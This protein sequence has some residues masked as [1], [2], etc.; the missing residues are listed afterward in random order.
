MM[1]SCGA[2]QRPWNLSLAYVVLQE[3]LS[4]GRP[5]PLGWDIHKGS[6]KTSCVDDDP[7][8]EPHILFC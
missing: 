6:S 2:V 8:Y 4:F 1:K 7:L 3:A 5:I